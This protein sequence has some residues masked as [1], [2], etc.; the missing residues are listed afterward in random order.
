MKN[1]E[2]VKENERK[3]EKMSDKK[4]EIEKKWNDKYRAKERQ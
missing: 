4:K 2:I 1:I 3:I